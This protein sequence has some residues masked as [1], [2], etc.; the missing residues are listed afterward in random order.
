MQRL[1]L[2]LA[3]ALGGCGTADFD[4][5]KGVI[6][7]FQTATT[8]TSAMTVGYFDDLNDFE[9]RLTFAGLRSDSGMQLNIPQ[10]FLRD[11]FDPRAIELRKQAFQVILIYT[12]L[13]AQLAG[14]DAPERWQASTQN[15]K[16]SADGLLSTIDKFAGSDDP[17]EK[18]VA[19]EAAGLLE[20]LR[21]LLSFAGTELINL[22]RTKALD[23]AVKTASPAIEALSAALKRDMGTVF[24]QRATIVLDPI[25]MLGVAYSKAQDAG[26]ESQRLRILDDLETALADRQTQLAE[27]RRIE[28]ALDTFDRA[29]GALVAY[30][31]SDKSP[32]SLSELIGE[33]ERYAMVAQ[34]AYDAFVEARKKEEK[35]ES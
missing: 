17:K 33:V 16:D 19:K 13:L 4:E 10:Q 21:I 5:Y 6:S 29:H 15:L 35:A 23:R 34:S 26:N 28:T 2:M 20:P 22:K 8:Q 31:E 1:A 30:A 11:P 25:A 32:Q 27:L 7:R 12:D 14:S 24:A 9:R 3:V 18:S